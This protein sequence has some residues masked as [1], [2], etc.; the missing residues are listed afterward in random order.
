MS[1]DEAPV[2]RRRSPLRWIILVG[3][4][5]ALLA[6]LILTTQAILHRGEETLNP[7][8][9]TAPPRLSATPTPSEEPGYGTKATPMPFPAKVANQQPRPNSLAGGFTVLD[10][11]AALISTTP[12]VYKGPKV[13][14]LMLRLVPSP[15]GKN[16]TAISKSGSWSRNEGTIICGRSL[17][18]S[19]LQCGFGTTSGELVLLE[20]RGTSIEAVR[21][22]TLDLQNHLPAS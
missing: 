7:P 15:A 12:I 1:A 18:G 21:E 13:A 8:L 10:G 2:A 5:L 9:L 11:E 20:G 6:G 16:E 17:T 14:T 19:A 3:L 4:F 22:A